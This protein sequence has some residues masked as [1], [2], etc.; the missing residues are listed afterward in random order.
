MPEPLD[1]PRT[2]GARRPES[3]VPPETVALR[4]TPRRRLG[5]TLGVG[6]GVA[7][8]VLALVLVGGSGATP[9]AAAAANV[10]RAVLATVRSKTMQ[11]TYSANEQVSGESVTL[12]GQGGCTLESATCQ[13]SET[14]VNT[15]T[16]ERLT[17]TMR[18]LHAEAYLKF[19]SP[20]AAHLPTPWVSVPFSASR[21]A[22]GS[23]SSSIAANPLSSL[24][25]LARGGAKVTDLGA[26]SVQGVP[27][28]EYQV[29]PS[30]GQLTAGIRRAAKVLPAWMRGATGGVSISGDTTDVWIARDGRVHQMQVT[31]T[32]QVARLTETVDLTL[33]VTGYGGRVEVQAPPSNEV[34]PFSK[35]LAGAST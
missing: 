17:L 34:T 28:T 12:S 24:A 16:A 10:H 6:A 25:A 32:V 1:L 23:G 15:A 3:S 21:L 5:V 7:A 19:G 30:T 18:E 13:L 31:E 9:S 33:H 8:V 11:F 20:L 22:P 4:P 29:V 27:M 14:V 26:T 2:V 35:V